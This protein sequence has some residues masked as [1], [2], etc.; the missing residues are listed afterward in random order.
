MF[1]LPFL[2]RLNRVQ[3]TTRKARDRDSTDPKLIETNNNAHT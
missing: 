3:I 2:R 1:G